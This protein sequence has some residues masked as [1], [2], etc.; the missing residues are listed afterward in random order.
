MRTGPTRFEQLTEQFDHLPPAEACARAW[1]S[2]G[3][4]KKAGEWHP[5]AKAEIER[6]MPLL[7]RALDRLVVDVDVEPVQWELWEWPTSS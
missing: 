7:A 1:V 2:P 4:P 5:R 6:L 3:P